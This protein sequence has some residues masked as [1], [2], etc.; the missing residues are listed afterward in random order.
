MDA[1][2]HAESH[3]EASMIQ[4]IIRSG[5]QKPDCGSLRACCDGMSLAE[6]SLVPSTPLV[7]SGKVI[8]DIY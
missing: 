5:E 8:W 6:M 2:T 3:A 1:E 4:S 7:A